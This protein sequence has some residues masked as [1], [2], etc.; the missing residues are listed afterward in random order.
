M[1]Q[2]LVTF[3]F[4]SALLQACG[5]P[6]DTERQAKRKATARAAAI[7]ELAS[8]HGAY[9]EWRKLLDDYSRLRRT[10][11]HEL[12]ESLIRPDGRPVI[13]ISS[14]N[15]IIKL[16]NGQYEVR[17][18]EQLG[19]G[20]DLYFRLSC[21]REPMAP[22]LSR[23]PELTDEYAFVAKISRLSTPMFQA[24]TDQETNGNTDIVVEPADIVVA[25]GQCIE[26][27]KLEE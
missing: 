17:G 3:L 20:P 27:T 9:I 8:K 22:L 23:P 4:V 7:S 18:H 10:Y 12:Q 25:V 24:P 15:D 6:L 14:V 5:R 1:K 26:I 21:T 19:V 13:L 11:T 2:V 16:D